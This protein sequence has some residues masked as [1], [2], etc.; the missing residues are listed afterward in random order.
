[1]QAFGK[2]HQILGNGATKY[3]TRCQAMEV[4]LR[5]HT[6]CTSEIPVVLNGSNVFVDSISFVIK[7]AAAL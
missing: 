3:M 1:M 5:T 4:V 2:G 7:A 6:N